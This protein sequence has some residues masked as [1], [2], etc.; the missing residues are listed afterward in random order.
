[1]FLIQNDEITKITF[2][3]NGVGCVARRP[4][5]NLS[6]FAISLKFEPRTCKWVFLIGLSFYNL[7]YKQSVIV[8]V[9]DILKSELFV[10]PDQ[11]HSR[12]EMFSFPIEFLKFF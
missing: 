8:V 5:F 1:M 3:Y 9:G 7:I 11:F 4:I 12:K 2:F 6:W 10:F